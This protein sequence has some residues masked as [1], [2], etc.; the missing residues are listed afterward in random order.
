MPYYALALRD[1]AGERLTEVL[2]ELQN[3][4]IEGLG[5][6]GPTGIQ[7]AFEQFVATRQLS[8]SPVVLHSWGG[9]S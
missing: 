9:L 6:F 7:E 1:L 5:S 4:F 2:P 8:G 3:L